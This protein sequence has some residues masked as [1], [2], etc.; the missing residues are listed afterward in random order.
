MI[1]IVFPFC[2]APLAANELEMATL[3][4]HTCLACPVCDN[5]LVTED[6]SAQAELPNQH[7]DVID[8]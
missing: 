2:H 8:A 3:D 6:T 5:L 7:V 4:G 1:R